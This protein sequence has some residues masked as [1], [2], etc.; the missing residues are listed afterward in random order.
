MKKDLDKKGV[1]QY[2]NTLT[3]LYTQSP[4]EEKSRLERSEN[5]NGQGLVTHTC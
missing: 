3:D 4:A 1:I 2:Y 5:M